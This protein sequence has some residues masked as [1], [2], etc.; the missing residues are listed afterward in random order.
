[1]TVECL[2]LV[3]DFMQ[4]FLGRG[5]GAK[6]VIRYFSLKNVPKLHKIEQSSDTYL[7]ANVKEIRVP[8]SGFSFLPVYTLSV[9]P[10][11]LELHIAILCQ[12]GIQ[13]FGVYW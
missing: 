7:L 1:M 3:L 12:H 10:L 13:H 11:C 4:L 5:K 9:F 8:S 2:P 6:R